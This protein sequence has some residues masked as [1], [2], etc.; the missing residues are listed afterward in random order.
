M[1]I[2]KYHD[3]DATGLNDGSSPANAYADPQDFVTNDAADLVTLMETATLNCR[4]TGGSASGALDINGFITDST[5]FVTIEVESGY[6]H[7]LTRTGFRIVSSEPFSGALYIQDNNVKIIGVAI[8]NTGNS[9]QADGVQINNIDAGAMIEFEDVLIYDCY[10]F[11]IHKRDSSGQMT[12]INITCYNTGL[13]AAGGGGLFGEGN[14]IY[15]SCT[16]LNVQSGTTYNGDGI[17]DDGFGV[18]EMANNYV[19]L[20]GGD[21]LNV[22][23]GTVTARTNGTDDTTG[24]V[25][26]QNLTA[27][28]GSGTY[29]TNITASSE[30]CTVT[31]N[32]STLYGEGTDLSGDATYPVTTDALGNSRAASPT[33]GSYEFPTGGPVEISGTIS[34]D[35]EL[36]GVLGFDFE[37]SGTVEGKGLL[38]GVLGIDMELSG[39]IEGEGLLSGD[40]TVISG[41]IRET[42]DFRRRDQEREHIMRHVADNK[43]IVLV[44][45]KAMVDD[46]FGGTVENPYDSGTPTTLKCR[47]FLDKRGPEGYE[48]NSIGLDAFGSWG[49]LSDYKN[50]IFEND[51]F[52]ARGRR[53]RIGVVTE[54]NRFGGIVGYQAPLIEAKEV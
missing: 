44:Y 49:I 6:Q 31:S 4:N 21:C 1:A 50:E 12:C 8:S 36:S 54:L 17:S 40:L 43:S 32:S 14:N 26:L 33:L 24:S 22:P 39:E 23:N 7:N 11:G 42:I 52:E 53:Y 5:Y 38:S 51:T 45:R 18:S 13:N 15:K 9:N 16:V 30:N 27:G 3:P 41:T 19:A 37:L 28:V 25:G 35:G 34:G 29:Q 48:G 10:R 46:G 2:L 47:L 20:C